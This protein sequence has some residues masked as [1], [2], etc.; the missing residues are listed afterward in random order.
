MPRPTESALSRGAARLLMLA[1]GAWLSL[2]ACAPP[3]TLPAPI[4]LAKSDGVELGGGA[5]VSLGLGE[6]CRV[7]EEV[8]FDTGI[9]YE[10]VCERTAVVFPD[11]A[12]WGVVPIND[13]WAVG[14]NVAVG[15]GTP[16]LVG[17][18]MGRYD[19]SKSD[20][21]LI[22]PQLE[23][24]VAW[25]ALGLP[26]SMQV[27]DRLWLYTHPSVG[28]RMSGL[29]RAPV[30]LGLEVGERMRL[31]MEA[32]FAV[33]M[34]RGTYTSYDSLTGTRTWLGVGLSS[35]LGR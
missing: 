13:Q 32:G 10:P 1:A 7:P 26:A 17:G 30:G 28:Y 25:G 29:A 6:D 22:G 18:A 12:H 19:I 9:I 5:T 21:F 2:W 4:P 27:N 31:D 35:R 14:W 33:P 15:L 3:S 34:M 20:R 11:A 23:L 16:G 8:A 24:G